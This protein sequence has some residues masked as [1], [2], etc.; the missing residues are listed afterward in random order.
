M[1]QPLT[2][3]TL[4]EGFTNLG[5]FEIEI[6]N[7]EQTITSSNFETLNAETFTEV[8]NHLFQ[9][10]FTDGTPVP[11]DYKID[12]EMEMIAGVD[13]VTLSSNPSSDGYASISSPKFPIIIRHADGHFPTF[14][15]AI[16]GKL[17]DRTKECYLEVTDANGSGINYLT[18]IT[19]FAVK[20]DVLCLSMPDQLQYELQPSI[21]VDAKKEALYITTTGKIYGFDKRTNTWDLLGQLGFKTFESPDKLDVQ[22]DALYLETRNAG[23]ITQGFLGQANTIFEDFKG[24]L[25]N[26]ATFKVNVKLSVKHPMQNDTSTEV[27]TFTNLK[28]GNTNIIP[29][30]LTGAPYVKPDVSPTLEAIETS[31]G[32]TLSRDFKD[33]LTNRGLNTTEKLLK[34]G[35]LSFID[36]FSALTVNNE[37]LVSVQ[38]HVDMYSLNQDTTQNQRIIDVG[39]KS[40]LDIANTP[41]SDFVSMVANE[42]IT[43]FEAAKIHEVAVQNMRLTSNL[44]AGTLNEMR[45]EQ[46]ELPNV[47]NSRFLATELS[48]AVNSCGCDDCKSNI[49][50]FAYL[51]DLLNY[52]SRTLSY[53]GVQSVDPSYRDPFSG[54]SE[55]ITAF[56][57]LLKRKFLQPFGE[58]Q[59]DCKTLHDEFCR[60]RLVTEVL[61]KKVA[62]NPPIGAQLNN[63]IKER[64]QYLLLVYQTLLV[65][66]GTSFKEIRKIVTN[67]N[68]TE[69]LEQAKKLSTRLSLPLYVP[70]TTELTVSRL[71]LTANATNP[72]NLLD[73]AK[74]ETLF[75]FRDTQ[76]DVLTQTPISKVEQWQAAHLR[77]TWKEQDYFVNAYTREGLDDTSVTTLINSI[78]PNWKPIIDPDFMGKEDITYRTGNMAAPLWENRKAYLDSVIDFITKD[79][80]HIQLL[81]ADIDKRILKVPM[82]NLIGHTFENNEARLKNASNTWVNFSVYGKNLNGSVTDIILSDSSL[83]SLQP[84]LFHVANGTD[85]MRY[86]RVVS[87][88]LSAIS[89]LG[90]NVAINWSD[91]VIQ[92]AVTNAF[93]PT[94]LS[95]KAGTNPAQVYET[96]LNSPLQLS[97]FTVVNDKK[98]T[99]I[100]SP[101]LTPSILTPGAIVELT[102]EVEVPITIDTCVN[103]QNLVNSLL[104]VPQTYQ[105]L[106]NQGS[107]SAIS[108]TIWTSIVNWTP[109]F[110]ASS[111]SVYEGLKYVLV[112]VLN[113]TLTLVQESFLNNNLRLSKAEFIRMMGILKQYEVYANN[114]FSSVKPSQDELYELATLISKSAKQQLLNDWV[115][116]EILLLDSSNNPASI[117]LSKADFWEAKAEP[118]SGVWDGRLQ[119]L[120]AG[121]V[122]LNANYAAIIDPELFSENDLLETPSAKVY[123]SVYAFRKKELSTKATAYKSAISLVQPNAISDILNEINTGSS[124]IPYS[125]LPYTN[126]T[127][128]VIDVSSSNGIQQQL[129]KDTIYNSFSLE[130]SDF[131]IIADIKANLESANPSVTPNQSEIDKC[132]RILTSAF[133]RQQ[134]SG[135]FGSWTL[136]EQTGSQQLQSGTPVFYYNV[137][138]MRLRGSMEDRIAW[139]RALAEWNR[140]PI[141]H[142]DIVP[143]ANIKNFVPSNPIRQLWASIKSVLVSDKQNLKGLFNSTNPSVLFDALKD[144]LEGFILRSKSFV[145]LTSTPN[146]HYFVQLIEMEANKEDIRPLLN[147]Y[148]ITY[149]QFK[150]ISKVYETLESETTANISI[151]NLINQELED[152]MDIFIRIKTLN[153]S[154]DAIVTE[155]NQGVSLTSDDFQIYR[156]APNTFPIT[157]LPKYNVW[158]S[159][160]KDRKDWK[161]ILEGRIDREKAVKDKWKDVLQESEDRVMPYMRDA[162]IRALSNVCE[163][164]QDAAERLAKTFFIETKDNCCVKHT[165]IS[166]AIETIQGLFFALE[167]GVFDDFVAN[168]TLNVISA[169]FK[170][171]WKWLGSYSTWR[172]A[173]FTHLYPENLLYPTLKRRQSPAFMELAETLKNAN[174]YS[175]ED[176]CEAGKKFEAY[177]NDIQN[178][179]I[180]CTTTAETIIAPL[181]VGSCCV[182]SNPILQYTVHYFGQSPISGRVYHSIK[183]YYTTSKEDPNFWEEIKIRNG[184]NPLG[185]FVITKRYAQSWT[186][187]EE[188]SLQLFYSYYDKG[189]LKLAYVKK[190]LEKYDSKWTDE[191]EVGALPYLGT[192]KLNPISIKAHQSS[193]DYNNPSFSIEYDFGLHKHLVSAIYSLDNNSIE[194]VKKLDTQI[195]LSNLSFYVNS[196]DYVSSLNILLQ[197]PPNVNFTIYH[198]VVTAK[199]NSIQFQAVQSAYYSPTLVKD[200]PDLIIDSIFESKQQPKNTILVHYHDPIDNSYFLDKIEITYTLQ[201]AANSSSNATLTL[202]LLNIQSFALSDTL[203]K[204]YPIFSHAGPFPF[205]NAIGVGAAADASELVGID[206]VL[207]DLFSYQTNELFKNTATNKP[208]ALTLDKYLT[209]QEV[210]SGECIKD[211]GLRSASIKQKLLQNVNPPE[212][213]ASVNITFST[214]TKELIYETYYFVPMLLG[215]DQQKRGQFEAAL[216]WYQSV[217][218]YTDDVNTNRKIFYGL[219]VESF[220]NNITN[221]SEDWLLDP[222]NPHSVAQTR[223]NAYTKYTVMNIVQCLYAYA[224]RLFTQDTIETVPMARKLYSQALELL[225]T[226]ELELRGNACTTAANPCLDNNTEV[227]VDDEWSET[228]DLLQERLQKLGNATLVNS[229]SSQIATLLNRATTTNTLEQG[230]AD[231]FEL[232]STSKTTPTPAKT[233]EELIS[234]QHTQLVNANRYFNAAYSNQNFNTTVENGFAQTVAYLSSL[235]P[236][237]L[238]NPASANRLTWLAQAPNT[239]SE[240]YSFSFRNAVGEQNLGEEFSYNPLA[241]NNRS[242]QANFNYANA[243]NLLGRAAP[244]PTASE[245]SYIPLMRYGFCMPKN[246]VYYGLHLKGHLELYKIFNCRNIAGMVRE[247]GVFAAATDSSTGMPV[248]GASGNLVVPGLGTYSPS[249]Y[250]FK[251]LMARAQQIAQQAQQLESLFLSALEK[252]DAETYARLRAKQDLDTA[253]ATIKLQD[254][255]INQA[256]SER[257]MADLQLNKASFANQYYTDLISSGYLNSERSSLQLLENVE[258]LYKISAILQYTS[259]LASFGSAGIPNSNPLAAIASGL[260]SIASGINSEASAVSSQISMLNQLASFER[261]KQEWNFQKDLSNFDISIANQQIKIADDNIRIVSQEREIAVLN[262]EHA[263]DSL[264]FLRTKFTNAELYNWM[265][266]VLE[267]AYSYM[268]NLSTAVARTAES[269]LY[270]ER[271]E[272][273]GPFIL[274]DYWETPS[275]GYT[276]GSSK[277]STD[278]R[279]LTGSARL[280]VDLT[281]LEQFAFDSNKRKL[282]ISK[283]ISLAQNFPS[284]F[285][286]FK[287][288]GV[289]NFALT[290]QQFDYDFPGHYLRLISSVKTTVVGLIPTYDGIKA[291]LTADS[292]SYTVIGGNTFQ[293]IPIRRLEIDS[294][295][296]SSPNNATGV[297]ELQ[298]Q[299]GELLNP[300]EGM[301]IESRWEFKMPQFSNRM[302]FDNIADVL[303]N[304]EYTALDSYQY[305]YQVLQDLDDSITFN[306]G[307]S[308]KNNF[309][310]QWYAL[311]QAQA[312][313]EP[314]GVDIDLKA[315]FFPDGM[316]DLKLGSENIVLYFARKDGYNAEIENF[317]F[318]LSSPT[319]APDS[320]LITANG[321]I[322]AVALANSLG[323]DASP[324][325]KLRLVF[326][327]NFTNRELFSEGKVKDILLLIP[328]KGDLKKYPL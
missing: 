67:T 89:I 93:G 275:S 177:Y 251:V 105:P 162:L 12:F 121:M 65:Q 295:A 237:E 314:F 63:L 280:L 42:T 227:S 230:F 328:C 170:A 179:K 68:A 154:Y 104:V 86:N 185:C 234:N 213:T 171:E 38:A 52:G 258:L 241:P 50:P 200:Y 49:S 183:P 283:T 43:N 133:K 157:D 265:G 240:N 284:E 302:N 266:N 317:N 60:V 24:V 164:F 189:V 57:A 61:E 262:T 161:D 80:N 146:L 30:T 298:A 138:K 2:G 107:N 141:V 294:V 3:L 196:S 125:I 64:S 188:L 143:A 140:L 159:P 156:S 160:N 184:A 98:V 271:Q 182:A 19:D 14:H 108:N 239:A 131:L 79:P 282:Q 115:R 11:P 58:F 82:R 180:I 120:P 226:P 169:K 232:V 165:R 135:S 327:N 315:E 292:I 301:G 5:N 167:N 71:W 278:R 219:I 203:S 222:L 168:F 249:Q 186:K 137:R 85:V 172:G 111:T 94:K 129:A 274:N 73:A 285:Q 312:S 101:N 149:E 151:T 25:R 210:K 147:Q 59:V 28:S 153:L 1:A 142:P 127:D 175:P 150:T 291:S 270:F 87:V 106:P 257:T 17:D 119:T 214:V 84:A 45:L 318:G 74:L 194:L 306:R 193:V 192:D 191:Q 199:K 152:V 197:N 253:K 245:P 155:Y 166:F 9:L 259:S 207:N 308:L 10:N 311:L 83:N 56:I 293:R 216:A 309:P 264:E 110:P 66:M 91:A 139:Q 248:I 304:V 46:S 90:P 128:L 316:D 310:D 211:Y 130:V 51:M 22:S 205:Q 201:S 252:E 36:G 273:A 221:R 102:Y 269:Q 297:F 305:R 77:Q 158:R 41:K 113:S 13:T 206:I 217:Y 235:N 27:F 75:G 267:R 303:I 7:I 286:R 288:T 320:G 224:D 173:M 53:K 114:A 289:L 4:N 313:T 97:S 134:L 118:S 117:Q 69:Q 31:S 296:L 181:G 16:T 277:G 176:A 96:F 37:E 228:Y 247:L 236:Q 263:Q 76:R 95:I 26:T 21:A 195:G 323:N 218:N 148:G 18:L 242:Y 112:S 281:R 246:P 254:L 202:S 215:L 279:G 123:R 23:A 268:L 32:L 212:G 145:Q 321:R 39:F 116:E 8:S 250:R 29:V 44:I 229:V 163:P 326:D 300:F 231:A 88:P 272:Q 190:N 225:N 62:L 54:S 220:R 307:F 244:T 40:I 48:P 33:F 103:P 15:Y 325:M 20:N 92:D 255:R 209:N 243:P 178:L 299:Q 322:E 261:R 132:T 126:F 99:F 198:C 260:S 109:I 290:N 78:K 233:V 256:K 122:L 34:A 124:A 72:V 47:P 81:S 55:N 319:L 174:R 204:I 276:A 238:N 223:R 208:F 100:T 35:P 136:E 6:T 287:E 70:N 187:P 144:V 324:V